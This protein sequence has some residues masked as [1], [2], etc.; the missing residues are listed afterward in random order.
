MNNFFLYQ[1]A[2]TTKFVVIP[3][4][5]NTSFSTAQWPLLFNLQE[6]VLARRLTSARMPTYK[7][8]VGRAASF[9]NARYLGPKL[10]QAYGL[11][12]DAALADPKKPYSNADFQ[13]SVAGL[14]SIIAGREADILAQ[15]K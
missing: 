3:W 7:G 4:D 12:R 9:V 2:N 5:K 13:A 8:E 10:D 6:N 1:Y 11:I 15:T 14:R